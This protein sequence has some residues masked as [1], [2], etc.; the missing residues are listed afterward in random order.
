MKTRLENLVDETQQFCLEM[1]YDEAKRPALMCS[2]GKDS[3]VLLHILRELEIDIPVIFFK[4]PW[5]PKKYK[6]AMD[7]IADWDL[8]VYDYP[9]V[10]VS[11]LYGKEIPAFVNDYE[12]AGGTISIPKNIVEY[13]DGQKRNSYLCARDDFFGRP[14]GRFNFLWDMVLVGHKDSDEDQIYGK[15]PLQTKVLK[16]EVGPSFCFP[17]KDW[18]TQDVW[19][20]S[21]KHRVPQQWGTRYCTDFTER[22]DKTFNSDYWSACIRCIDKRKAGE[23]VQCP[24]YNTSLKNISH[25]VPEFSKVPDYFGYDKE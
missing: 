1:V 7:V 22:E 24:K 18:T 15:V 5:Q 13:E 25:L 19:D 23:V 17:L 6:F 9:P 3:M 20:Y 4:D 11:M 2:F 21:V 16:R 10:S 14:L 8:E 12:A